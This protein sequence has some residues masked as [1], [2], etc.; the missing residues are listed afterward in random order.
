VVGD[1]SAGLEERA[2][3]DAVV[4]SAAFT[5]VPPPLAEQ[6][7]TGGR[8]VMPIGPGGRDAVLRFV[9]RPDGLERAGFLTDAH[10]VRLYGVHA[11]PGR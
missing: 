6:V 4:V 3:F 2:P 1:G 7:A 5:H 10:F 9:K 11:F 8:L